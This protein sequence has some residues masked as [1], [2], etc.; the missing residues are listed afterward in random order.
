[1]LEILRADYA[2]IM[3]TG[4]FNGID[5]SAN[6]KAQSKVLY[7]IVA[8]IPLKFVLSNRRIWIKNT[9]V[10]AGKGLLGQSHRFTKK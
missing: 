5:K 10:N 3:T 8:V 4:G 9:I 6:N 2:P 7:L 1:M